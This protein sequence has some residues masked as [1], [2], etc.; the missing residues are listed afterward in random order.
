LNKAI[1]DNPPVV[2]RDGGVIAPGFSTELDE[3]RD[4]AQGATAFLEA[5]EQRERER[6]GIASLKVNYNKVHGFYI[7]VSR[8]N[9]EAVPADYVRRQTLKNNER[10]IIP[11]LRADTLNLSA[12][13]LVNDRLIEY[14]DGRHL[15]VEEVM[16]GPFIANPLHMS[17][18]NQMLMITPAQIV[19][20]LW[21]RL[22]EALAPMMGFL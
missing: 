14:S 18:A 15:V 9:S 21:M 5:L 2:L 10:Y 20:Y 6:T 16:T 11:E 8:A 12:P 1:V 7:E 13:K 22:A 4:L 3:L 19:W 17:E